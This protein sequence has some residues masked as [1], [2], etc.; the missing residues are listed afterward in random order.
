[1]HGHG[2]DRNTPLPNAKRDINTGLKLKPSPKKFIR[3]MIEHINL[4][5]NS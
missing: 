3:P 1:M 2:T 5:S 4:K